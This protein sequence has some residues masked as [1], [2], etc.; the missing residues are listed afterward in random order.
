MLATACGGASEPRPKVIAH[1][2]GSG[3][4]PENSRTAVRG[5]I[6][7]GYPG[8][9]FD[10]T[11]TRDLVPVLAH[12]PWLNETL[13]TTA[14]GASL[15]GRVFIQDLTLQELQE[16]YR[17]GGVENSDAP[18]AEVVPDTLM[19]LDEVLDALVAAPEMLVHIDLKCEPE[20]TPSAEAFAEQILGRW[21]ARGLPNPMYVD[22]GLPAVLEAFRA[23]GPVTTAL[24]WP[25]FPAGG[26]P[27]SIVIE[28][29][30]LTRLG[31]DDMV[32][33]A[34][35]AG[36]DG[37]VIPYQMADQHLVK[38]AHHE[39]LQVQVFSPNSRELLEY[40]CDWPVDVLITDF[41][42][43]ASCLR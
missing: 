16:G 32:A 14:D 7:R 20:L 24:S 40:F 37:V 26:S 18:D 38:R 11:L 43:E 30:M 15:S 22:S 35:R 36:S 13:C 3:N 8:M 34:T 12:D 6:A 42:E 5:S 10:V 9:E 23:R 41:P 2:A 39:G 17:C 27:T 25:W 4:W 31:L 28:H 33:A 21:Q 19:T 1:R 29:E